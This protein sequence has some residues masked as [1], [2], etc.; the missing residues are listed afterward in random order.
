MF[1]DLIIQ[2]TCGN[3]AVCRLKQYLNSEGVYELNQNYSYFE[4]A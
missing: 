2:G 4:I 3:D 1:Q